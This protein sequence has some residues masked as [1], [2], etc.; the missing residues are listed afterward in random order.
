MG[1]HAVHDQERV[2]ENETDKD[3]QQDRDRF[4][5]PTQVEQHEPHDE[6][7]FGCKLVWLEGERKQRE[8]GIDPARDRNR[9]GEHVIEN[10]RGARDEARI[11]ADQARGDP[12]AAPARGKQLDDLVVGERDDEHGRRRGEREVQPQIGVLA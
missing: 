7:D 1:E 5:H 4:P 3:R 12:V 6:R 10:E 2:R 9:D 8:Q 11:G